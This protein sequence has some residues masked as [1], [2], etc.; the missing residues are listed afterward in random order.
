ML[1]MK[2]FKWRY[3]PYL[4]CSGLR[5]AVGTAARRHVEG[6]TTCQ[7]EGTAV[8]RRWGAWRAASRSRRETDYRELMRK[9]D[10]RFDA[11][12]ACQKNEER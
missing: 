2:T 10:E 7:H 5:A 11:H 6:F 8:Q 3:W 9:A 1:Y 4:A 12:L